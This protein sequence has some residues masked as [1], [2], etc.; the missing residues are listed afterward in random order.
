M[1][2]IFYKSSV[3][4]TVKKFLQD[5]KDQFSNAIED[6]RS[7]PQSGGYLSSSLKKLRKWKYRTRNVPYRIVYEIIADERIDV[8]A[9]GKRKNFYDRL[10]IK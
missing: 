2:K 7:N 1:R 5:E 8:I 10:R 4:K 6:I 3:I 9:V